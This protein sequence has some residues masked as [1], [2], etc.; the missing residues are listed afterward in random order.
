[1]RVDGHADR[2]QDGIYAP[3][4]FNDRLLL[5]SEGHDGEAELHLIR[6]R[7]DGGLR[8]KAARGELRLHLPVGLERDE[9]D[10]IVLSPDEQVRSAI[11]QV[12]V[13]WRRLGSAR[14]VLTELS[15]REARF[16]AAGSVSDA[17]GGFAPELQRG[18]RLPDQPGVRRDVHIRPD[19]RGEASRPSTDGCGSVG[20]C[21]RVEEWTVCLPD[22][23]PGYVGWDEYL[24]TRERLHA[25]MRPRGEGGGAAREG[26]GLLQGL[27]RCGRCGRQMQVT[28]SGADGSSPRYWCVPRP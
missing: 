22:H 16:R 4:E 9:D 26:A 14:Q 15:L 7:L 5:R 8:N 28:Y 24:A 3:G 17:S 21:C 18:A 23:H 25:N 19:A 12:F 1:M 20:S 13:L 10:R 27:V 11:E 2:R 6:A